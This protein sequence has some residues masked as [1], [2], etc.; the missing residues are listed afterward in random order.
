MYEFPAT[1]IESAL[2]HPADPTDLVVELLHGLE[3]WYQRWL[4]GA[5]HPDWE[6]YLAYRL[7]SVAIS[8]DRPEIRGRVL[9]LTAEGALRLE[10]ESGESIDIAG[11]GARLRPVESGLA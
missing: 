8:G 11:G 9:G 6:H 3:A 7:E 4:E 1:S 2:G 10:A 5:A